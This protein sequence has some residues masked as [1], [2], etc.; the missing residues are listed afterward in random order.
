MSEPV[1]LA[2]LADLAWMVGHW[3][4]KVGDDDVEEVWLAEAGGQMPMTF[5]WL[6]AG[7][8]RIYEFGLLLIVDDH[9]EM[10]LR[11]L[12]P[13]GASIEAADERTNFRLFALD[14]RKA[15]FEDL[16]DANVSLIYAR[17]G[18]VLT[19]RFEAK[20]GEPPISKPFVYRKI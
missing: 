10:R 15:T 2:D 20:E 6:R 13:T 18:D 19:A 8:P 5:R 12:R 7:Q 11:H 9:A 3:R 16:S 4:G 17:E 14:D 1:R